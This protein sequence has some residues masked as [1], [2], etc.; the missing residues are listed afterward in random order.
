MIVLMNLRSKDS[1]WNI[2]LQ[3]YFTAPPNKETSF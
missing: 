1:Y 3:I 2:E